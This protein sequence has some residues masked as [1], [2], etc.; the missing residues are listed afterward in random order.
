V[1]VRIWQGRALAE[2]GDAYVQH[3]RENVLS[4]LACIAGFCGASLLQRERDGIVEFVAIT[5]FDSLASVRAFAGDDYER[6]VV[7]PIARE[8]L[9]D[10]D[11]QVTH[12]VEL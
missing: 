10:F 8:I 1:I 5:R 3:F 9:L 4:E 2:H 12:Y 7:A 11:E 6:A